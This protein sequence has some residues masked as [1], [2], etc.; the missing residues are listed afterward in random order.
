MAIR[1]YRIN[2]QISGTQV[3]LLGTEGYSIG[4][5]PLSEA[6]RLANEAQMDL[7]E[8]SRSDD[9][10]V[11]KIAD[12]KKF[13]YELSQKEKQAKK[14]QKKMTVKEIRL[15]PNIE[16]HDLAT[17]RNAARKFL[18]KGER[19]KV[20]LRFRGREIAFLSERIHVLS[21]FADSLQ[22]IS[23]TEQKPKTEGKSVTLVLSP[24]H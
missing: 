18:E 7:I 24:K 21:D 12:Y 8:L 5:V 11:C 19:V 23:V 22:D 6:L 10:P 15:S 2:E 9:V 3:R 1:T 16:A 4:V 17:K 14:K 20:V 13:L